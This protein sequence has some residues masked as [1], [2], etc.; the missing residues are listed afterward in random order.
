MLTCHPALQYNLLQVPVV[1]WVPLKSLE[2]LGP[3]A[4]F[5]FYQVKT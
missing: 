3:L 5:L 4:V 2:Q 1:S